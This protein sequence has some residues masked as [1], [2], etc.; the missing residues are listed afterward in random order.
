MSIKTKYGN[1]SIDSNGYYQIR[2]D[3][4]SFRGH[5][6]HRL[7]MADAI[8][9]G[10]PSNYHV[11]HIDGNKLN[12]DLNNLELLTIEEHSSIHHK[13]KI[14]SLKSKIK[15]SKTKNNTCEYY[16]VTKANDNRYKQG[17][18][19]RYQYVDNNGKHQ[20]ISSTN[21]KKLEKKVR[22]KELEWRKL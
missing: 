8:G 18:I 14:V 3:E 21:L 4:Y 5:K 15:L 1:A 6:L 19:Y 2:S 22:E 12:N 9:C 17:F 7:I 10:I 11:H 16:R 20:S 13:N